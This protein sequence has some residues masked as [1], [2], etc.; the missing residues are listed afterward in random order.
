MSAKTHLKWGK[1]AKNTLVFIRLRILT[2]EHIYI[3]TFSLL[4]YVKRHEPKPSS[5][6]FRYVKTWWSKIKSLF[7]SLHLLQLKL[8]S[9]LIWFRKSNMQTISWQYTEDW[10]SSG[11]FISVKTFRHRRI[12]LS[13]TVKYNPVLPLIICRKYT[14][15]TLDNQ[16]AIG[17][18]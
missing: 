14:V 1:T 17:K 18:C 6:T 8:M 11:G 15:Y 10:P 7:F 9:I 5:L 3:A 2:E 16:A 4:G 12:L 13:G